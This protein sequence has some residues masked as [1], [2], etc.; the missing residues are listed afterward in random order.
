LGLKSAKSKFWNN[1]TVQ[2]LVVGRGTGALAV[3]VFAEP[4]TGVLGAT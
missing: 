2:G 4:I 1:V 3:T